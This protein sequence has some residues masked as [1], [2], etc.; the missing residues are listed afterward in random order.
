MKEEGNVAILKKDLR[1]PSFWGGRAFP[2][3]GQIQLFEGG[4]AAKIAVRIK[5]E[6]E[7]EPSEDW[8]MAEGDENPITLESGK[9]VYGSIIAI[10]GGR[11][12]DEVISPGFRCKYEVRWWPGNWN[13]VRVTLAEIVIRGDEPP[14]I[15]Y[16]ETF[17]FQGE[18]IVQTSGPPPIEEWNLLPG[19]TSAT[20]SFP[21]PWEEPEDPVEYRYL[22]ILF[23][24]PLDSDST[25]WSMEADFRP[26]PIGYEAA[27]EKRIWRANSPIELG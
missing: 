15:R 24:P 19:F 4:P 9:V 13:A 11:S 23:P 27:Y 5:G 17:E 22:V 1:S 3:H 10:S 25:P 12:G 8:Q 16:A 26:G 20:T 2:L 14:D 7:L 6:F 18:P 21:L